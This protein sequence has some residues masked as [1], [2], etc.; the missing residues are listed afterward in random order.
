MKN[1]KFK[2][3]PFITIL[4]LFIS[5]EDFIDLE[6]LDQIT[7]DNYWKSSS[8]LENYMLQ[9]YPRFFPDNGMI[10]GLTAH[11]DNMVFSNISTIMHGERSPRTG[12]WRW[13]WTDIRNVNVFFANYEKCEDPLSSY[14]QY[15]GEAHFFRAWFYFNM[16]K[17]YGDLPWYSEPIEL[18]DDEALMK[19]RE[20]RTF[21]A[22]KII[23]DLDNA[24]IYL[25]K[26]EKVGNNRITK[27][28]A[29]AFKTRVAL[30]EGTWQKYHAGT[31]FGTSGS[32]PDK[33]FNAC[34]SAAKELMSG[35]YTVGIYNTG[36]P[37]IDYFK[38]FGLV[39]MNNIDEVI[40]YK[41]FN[42]AE[43]FG[44]TVEGYLSHNADGKGVTWDLV[45]SYL[46]KDGEPYDYLELSKT[47]KGNSFLTTIAENCD[48][49]LKSTI[50]IPG[51]YRSV[52]LDMVFD[53]PTI[54][55]GA[56]QLCPTGFQIKKTTD[57]Y[58]RGAGRTWE[59]G[60]E[61]GLIILRYGE[62]LL[63]YAEAKCELDNSV[64]Y[65]QLN[66]LRNR[67]GM[68]YFKV[69]PQSSDPN[70]SDYG[71]TISD[72]LYEIRRERN[73][74][75]ALEGRRQEDYMRWR[76]HTLFKGKRPKGYPLSH[77]EFPN[78]KNPIDENE[79][80]DY[81][82]NNIPNGYGFR[83]N[84]DY[85]YSIPQDEITLNPNLIQNPGWD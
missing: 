7:V 23:E 42:H 46:G 65:E 25:D 34:V 43:G 28:A 51:D 37:D 75:L 77:D 84:Q 66:L 12:S 29:L 4:L 8:D 68:T 9:F 70:F 61:T 26:R 44:N 80:I 50:Y 32:N 48:P 69:N 14:S 85:L 41:A 45:S 35:E 73:V 38:M 63:N 11:T 64:A 52:A 27:E 22:D 19:P 30:Y 53:K 15:L 71:Y 49:R 6:P 1:I 59:I 58:S 3:I 13:E 62:V 72:E 18:E 82:K 31:V 2:L 36:E 78:Y 76:A 21:I 5:C 24:A 17:M 60:S 79:L 55:E 81:Y 39:N 74:E 33:Y 54:D 10:G 40:L 56:L 83:P 67:A 16:L 47:T 20:P 57:P